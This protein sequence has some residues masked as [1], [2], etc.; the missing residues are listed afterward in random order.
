MQTFEGWNDPRRRTRGDDSDDLV[1]LEDNNSP[2][3]SETSSDK[4]ES[5]ENSIPKQPQ[6]LTSRWSDVARDRNSTPPAQTRQT[7]TVAPPTTQ[8]QVVSVQ[9]PP[10]DNKPPALMSLNVPKPPSLS[11]TQMQERVQENRRDYGG[12]GRGRDRRERR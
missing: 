8:Q 5:R 2:S 7:P 4:N 9:Q 3:I 6:P 10:P 12:R 1:S 11:D